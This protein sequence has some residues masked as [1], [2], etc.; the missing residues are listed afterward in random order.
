LTAYFTELF[1]NRRNLLPAGSNETVYLHTGTP[2]MAF[3]RGT[4]GNQVF[5][6]INLSS[7]W[8]N[9]DLKSYPSAKSLIEG[10]EGNMIP[11][12]DYHIYRI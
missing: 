12:Y 11:P 1:T 8:Q 3:L 4:A 9:V 7:A 10:K 6:A 2:V 5:V